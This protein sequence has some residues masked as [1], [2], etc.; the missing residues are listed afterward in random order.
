LGFKKLTLNRSG[1]PRPL[2]LSGSVHACF[3]R[4]IS[5]SWNGAGPYPRQ[6][7]GRWQKAT[8]RMSKP[9]ETERGE[10]GFRD[11]RRRGSGRR[12]HSLETTCVDGAWTNTI[13]A[14]LDKMACRRLRHLARSCSALTSDPPAFTS[15][16]S[17]PPIGGFARRYSGTPCLNMDLSVGKSGEKR[18]LDLDADFG[19]R[20]MRSVVIELVEFP[21]CWAWRSPSMQARLSSIPA[22][23][24][25]HSTPPPKS[26]LTPEL[27]MLSHEFRWPVRRLGSVRHSIY[28]HSSRAACRFPADSSPRSAHSTAH[29]R[30]GCR[31]SCH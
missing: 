13:C 23:H 8:G 5:A 24:S 31:A 17:W 4:A 22:A 29:R 26:D 19:P 11:H 20:T 3:R 7:D 30:I 14:L 9:N 15:D 2:Q 12:E 18:R 28:H 10:S 21:G 1:M 16:W 6:K 27:M 25:T